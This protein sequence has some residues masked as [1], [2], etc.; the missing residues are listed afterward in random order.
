VQRLLNT[1]AEETSSDTSAPDHAASDSS[2]V[3]ERSQ[4]LAEP[5]TEPPVH[6]DEIGALPDRVSQITGTDVRG[7]PI[8]ARDV[9]DARAITHE[10]RVTLGANVTQHDV[11]HE[12][13]H[14][15]QQQPSSGPSLGGVEAEQRADAVA[16]AALS[17][18]SGS[19]AAGRV[20]SAA[21]LR[22]G[23]PYS[24][25]AITLTAPPAGLTI[26]DFKKQLELKIKA[27]DITGYSISGVKTGDPE[28]KFLYNALILLA[29]KGRWGSELD[30]V[31]SIGAGKGE[32][33]VRFDASG[34]AEAQ[35]VGK[36]EPTV[37]AAFAKV[38]DARDAL[39][40][41]YKLKGVKGENGRSWSIDELNKV[42]AAWS[43]LS[44]IEAAAL[45]GYTLIRIDKLTLA[46]ES[47]Q[48]QTTHT[49]EVSR[50][51]TK[52]THVREIRFADRA[53]GD[54]DKS[55]IGDAA[56]A[57]PASFEVLIHEV[58]HALEGKPFDDLNAPATDDAAKANKAKNDAH[59]AQLAANDAINAA[60]GKKFPKT[61]L[62]AGQPLFDA[63]SA[64]LKVLKEFEKTTDNTHE[65]AAT[66]AIADR[67]A[68]K[69]TIAK[70][71]K[72]TAALAPAVTAQ[73][74]YL[75][76]LKKFLAATAAAAASSAKADALKS[77]SNTT[78]LQLFIDFV[79][80]EKIPPPTAYAAKHWPS[81][82]AEF[83]DEAFSLWKNDPVFF[84]RY[85]PKLKAWFDAGNHL[86]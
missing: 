63:I 9:P 16:S 1:H 60:L 33:T 5:H 10:A 53:F 8:D 21:V 14:A 28:E 84:A 29:D 4:A 86:K 61:D 42:H 18:Q 35:L 12:L 17:G 39:I 48:G 20:P 19:V 69:A 3:Q 62:A 27:G 79:T 55:F 44:A 25:E 23:H 52:A 85:S 45:E 78:R 50:G 59:A 46:G 32:V 30:L 70:G 58:G 15:A 22:A 77:G 13:A 2:S 24:R 34:K 82:P 68:V 54:D 73:N 75:A 11:A 81:R 40:A 7:V 74:A 80:K 71:N 51:A 76:A 66:K 57:A 41:T 36:S 47:V 31:T 65:A 67:D 64:A 49:D 37:K 83:F 72:V 26:D 43:R 56:D 6:V 38:K